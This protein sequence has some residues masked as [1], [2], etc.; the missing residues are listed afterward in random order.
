MS[1][2][3]GDTDY[4]TSGQG[5]ERYRR[6]DPRIA[7]LL[8]RQLGD[9]CCV[10]NVGAGAGSYEPHDRYVL[11]IEPSPAMRARR[12]ALKAVPAI[13]ATV[14]TLP[15]DDGAVDAA[16]A[17]FTVHQWPDVQRGLRNI[18]RVTAGPVVVMTLDPEAL[19]SLWFE[20]YFPERSAMERR[21]FPSLDDIAKGLGGTVDVTVAPIPVDCTDGFIEAYYGRPEALLDRRVRAAQSGWTLVDSTDVQNSLERLAHDVESGAWDRRYGRLRTQPVL[22]G[23][24]VLLTSRP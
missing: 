19:R 12:A 22:H 13:D 4:E 10:L 11:A 7:A 6:P 24:L 1:G 9:A 14:D 5:Y 21:R 20:D 3:A 23:P 16:M 17:V 15:F 18:R 8:H 2:P